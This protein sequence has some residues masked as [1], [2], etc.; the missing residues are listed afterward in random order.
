[1]NAAEF[2]EFV[3]KVV[4]PPPPDRDLTVTEEEAQSWAN[5][6]LDPLAQ[7]P[8]AG[9]P[10]PSPARRGLSHVVAAAVAILAFL[11]GMAIG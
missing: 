5:P 3:V 7:L 8:S 9:E 1:M 6:W 11:A 10:P 4:G 2:D